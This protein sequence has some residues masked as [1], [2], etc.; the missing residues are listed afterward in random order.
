MGRR[1]MSTKSINDYPKKTT[2]ELD[3]C[4]VIG[5]Y[6]TTYKIKMADLISNLQTG[7][8]KSDMGASNEGKMLS[9]DI[10]GNVVLVDPMT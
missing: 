2:F 5:K 6:G 9:I 3:D 4:T 10:D 1:I 7:K 8:L